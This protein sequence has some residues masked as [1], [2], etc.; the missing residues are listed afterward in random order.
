MVGSGEEGVRKTSFW[1]M[2][3][4]GGTKRK[5]VEE[6]EGQDSQA[7]GGRGYTE[8]QTLE[9]RGGAEGTPLGKR[10][11]A[12]GERGGYVGQASG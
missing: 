1:R 7:L 4:G 10:G 3:E 12:L 2:E 11:K 9:E 8:G 6:T 5:D